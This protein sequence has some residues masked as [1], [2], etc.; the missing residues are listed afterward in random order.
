M[1]GLREDN[2]LI[3]STFNIVQGSIIVA[4]IVKIQ[5]L[6]LIRRLLLSLRGRSS[7]RGYICHVS[8]KVIDF[9]ILNFSLYKISLILISYLKV[10]F[11]LCCFNLLMVALSSRSI[12][13][14]RSQR[15][16]IRMSFIDPFNL[17]GLLEILSNSSQILS[18]R[19]HLSIDKCV[20][21]NQFFMLYFLRSSR[22]FI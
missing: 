16:F 5:F 13:N 8:V 15:H 3:I 19:T 4:D 18:Y 1:I 17:K 12:L 6:L 20:S 9:K 10:A 2:F 21:K 22:Q 14:F 7:T 11:K